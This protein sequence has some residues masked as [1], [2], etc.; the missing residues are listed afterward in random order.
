MLHTS[1]NPS[2]M[3]SVLRQTERAHSLK[4]FSNLFAKSVVAWNCYT[5]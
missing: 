3:I 4:I 1:L 5:I 2:T